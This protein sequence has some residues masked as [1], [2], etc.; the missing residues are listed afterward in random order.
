LKKIKYFRITDAPCQPGLD[1]EEIITISEEED[2]MPIFWRRDE[3]KHREIKMEA[4]S[5]QHVC[6]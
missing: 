2:I 3:L 6:F 5:F 1:T 4:D